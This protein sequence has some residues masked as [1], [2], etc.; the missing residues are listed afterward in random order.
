MIRALASCPH[1]SLTIYA[2]SKELSMVT[3]CWTFRWDI[4]LGAGAQSLVI[5]AE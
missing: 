1:R 2:S 5:N 3:S 4:Q